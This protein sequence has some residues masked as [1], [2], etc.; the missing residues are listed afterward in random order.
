[1]YFTLCTF[2][3]ASAVFSQQT[4]VVDFKTI[5]AELSFQPKKALVEGVATISFE[6]L[7]PTDSVFIDAKK[8]EITQVY[9]ENKKV[10]FEYNNQQIIY[11][12]NFKV[13]KTYTLII[14]YKA[15]PTKALYFIDWN[16]DETHA[17]YHPQLWTQGQ[18]KYT[19]NWLPSIDD[20]N[21]KI[22]FDLKIDFNK[23]FE[24]IANGKLSTKETNGS[25]TSWHYKMNQPMSS[26]L[27]ALAIGKYGS[28]AESSKSGIPLQFYYYS[29]DSLK[30]ESTYRYSKQLFD[31]LEKEIGVAYPW[32]NYKQVPV[33]DFLYSGMEN[34]SCTIFSDAFVV[35]DI[36][37]NDN[38]YVNVNAHELAHQWFGDLVTET[39]GTHHW[40]QEGFATYYALLAEKEIFGEDYYYDQLYKY[41]QELLEQDLV[42]QSTAL[43]NPNSSSVTFYKKGAWALHMLR[44]KVGDVAFRTAVKTYLNTYKFK[45][46][47]TKNFIAEVERASNKNLDEFVKSWLEDQTLQFEAME[48]SLNKSNFY[49]E[50]QKTDCEVKNGKCKDWLRAPISD[51]AKTRIIN[52]QPELVFEETF[53][54]SLK[55]RQAIAFTLQKIPEHLKLE[56]E[57]LLN[58]AS[59]LTKEAALYKLWVNFPEDRFKYLDQTK[60]VIGDNTKNVRLLWLILAL[61][62]VDYNNEDKSA[63]FRELVAYTSPIY[64]F[65]VRQAAFMYLR[66]LNAITDEVLSHLKE[67]TKHHNWRFKNFAQQLL[68]SQTNKKE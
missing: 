22:V 30:T 13:G 16:K 9:N 32:Q 20:M 15:H 57:T 64:P 41:S 14:N 10:D 2:L 62:T 46:V 54:N 5:S 8:M 63:Y 48:E 24:V 55:T 37:F 68:E 36:E 35:D 4:K 33:K 52:Q 26:Y 53:S 23:D 3:I 38:N 17:E 18:G 27:V 29:E 19:S 34:T 67:A 58:D 56:F 43:L 50:F 51:I 40:L 21:D 25:T 11:K 66:D 65:Y 12:T 39:S 31:G 49:Q 45:N 47:E 28:F 61:N 7:Q 42:G 44:E 1:M 59:Y 60:A 6:V